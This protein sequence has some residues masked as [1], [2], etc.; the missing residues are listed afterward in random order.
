MNGSEYPK[1]IEEIY[2]KKL[3]NATYTPG[4][5]EDIKQY[6]FESDVVVP[7]RIEGIPIIILEALSLG[8]SIIAS[9][10]GGISIIKK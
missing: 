3:A 8:V 2:N 1:I 10:N 6:L 5:V 7:S 4:F 9:D